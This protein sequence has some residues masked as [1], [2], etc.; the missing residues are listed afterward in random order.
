MKNLWDFQRMDLLLQY[1]VLDEGIL[2][3]KVNI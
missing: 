1:L 2:E 3:E